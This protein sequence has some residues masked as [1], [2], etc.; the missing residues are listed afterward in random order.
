MKRLLFILI[1]L[2]NLALT[3]ACPL[4]G[5][6]PKNYNVYRVYDEITTPHFL[7]PNY[8]QRNLLTWQQQIGKHIPL[9]Q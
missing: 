6:T 7:T 3:H 2:S 8:K 4:T 1:L 5:D 9:M